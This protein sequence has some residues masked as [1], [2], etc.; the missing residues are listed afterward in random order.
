MATKK[1]RAALG[2]E[3]AENNQAEW[4][5]SLDQTDL[6]FLAK[7][8]VSHESKEK[9]LYEE[10]TTKHAASTSAVSAANLLQLIDTVN[11]TESIAQLRKLLP[12]YFPSQR[13]VS[14][15]KAK[16]RQ[17]FQAVLRP[18]R[19]ATGWKIDPERL[20]ECLLFRYII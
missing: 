16:C 12:G 2:A 3:E 13:K 6:I 17:E 4:D 5:G 10:L 14:T 7:E 20:R 19:T 11:T 1:T 9:S 15:L 8:S 18:S